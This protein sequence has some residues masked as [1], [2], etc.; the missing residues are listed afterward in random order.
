MGG[1]A[2]PPGLVAQHR[3]GCRVGGRRTDA[4]QQP[5][6]D[7]PAEA[8]RERPDETGGDHDDQTGEEDAAGAEGV[9]ELAENGLGDGAGEVEDRD[10]PGGVG[11]TDAEGV[12][13]RH[14]GGGDHGGVERVEQGA[15]E[16]RRGEART[17]TGAGGCGA[18]GG[19][20][21]ERADG[22]GGR[23]NRC[24]PR[25]VARHTH[26]HFHRVRRCRFRAVTARPG[27]PGGPWHRRRYGARPRRARQRSLRRASCAWRPGPRRAWSGRRP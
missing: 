20:G 11:G 26:F 2:D 24:R 4:E 9:G 10:E 14:Q 8:R 21:R 22:S 15:E 25:P 17:E 13:D 5:G 16:Q 6:C 27:G 12:T 3:H 18:A 7:Q 1:A 23:R 19:S